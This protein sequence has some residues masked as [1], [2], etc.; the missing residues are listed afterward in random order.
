MPLSTEEIA[1]PMF[2]PRRV[3]AIDAELRALRDVIAAAS[4]ELAEVRC[5]QA[6]LVDMEAALVVAIEV[7]A[8]RMDD[9][10]DQRMQAVLAG[11]VPG[12]ALSADGPGQRPVT[13]SDGVPV[14]AS[15]PLSGFR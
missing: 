7:R 13:G 11:P 6:D 14:S 5:R 4:T 2:P 9:L 15:G 10:L 3:T 12:G 8:R 1:V